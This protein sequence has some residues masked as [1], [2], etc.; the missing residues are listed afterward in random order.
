MKLNPLIA[1]A[2]AFLG[3]SAV[4]HAQSPA[5]TELSAHK[6]WKAFTYDGGGGKMCYVA[7]QLKDGSSKYSKPIS[8]RDG[9]YFQVTRIPSQ[10]VQNEASAIAGYKFL[11]NSEV[12]VDVDG[13]KFRMFLDASHPDTAWVEPEDEAALIEAM[14]KGSKL[15]FTGTSSRNTLISDTFSLSGISAALD[16]IVKECP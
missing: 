11:P 15:V 13:T 1:V 10:N 6:D 2:A 3:L 9:A 8:G 4:A 16:A 7:T 12:S 5:A 14:R